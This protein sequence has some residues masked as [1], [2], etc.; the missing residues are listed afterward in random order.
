MEEVKVDVLQLEAE[1]ALSAKQ[2]FFTLPDAPS[3]GKPVRFLYNRLEGP[4]PDGS[5]VSIKY[6]LNKWEEIGHIQMH[7]CAELDGIK[8]EWWEAEHEL[9][10]LLYRFDFVVMDD[11]SGLVDNNNSKDFTLQL[12]G[13]LTKEQLLEKRLIVFEENEQARNKQLEHEIERLT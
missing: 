10:P 9:H 8:G 4:L 12:K 13:A 7:K 3:I 2:P 6:G 5:S 1:A 11:V